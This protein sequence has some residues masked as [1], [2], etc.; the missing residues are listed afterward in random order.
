MDF[1]A[2]EKAW[3]SKASDLFKQGTSLGT[4]ETTTANKDLIKSYKNALYKKNRLWWNKTSLENY[5]D[6]QIIPRGLRVQIYPSFELGDDTL[7][8]RWISAAMTCSLDFM[9][10]IVDK[11]SQ[12]LKILDEEI[13]E[14]EKNIL[15]QLPVDNFDTSLAEINKE[16]DKWE[17]QISQNKLKKLQRDLK[18]YENDKIYRWQ[19]K[20][21]KKVNKE[22][23]EE[24][25]P[26]LSHERT[27]SESSC[28]STSDN[29][30]T[31]ASEGENYTIRERRPRRGN[32]RNEKRLHDIFTRTK[33]KKSFGEQAKV[34]NLSQ[35]RITETQLRLLEKGLT[36]SP[37]CR[38][39]PFTAVKDL[40][41][42]AR[43]LIFKKFHYKK[44]TGDMIATGEENETLQILESLLDENTTPTTKYSLCESV[45]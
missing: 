14:M 33:G 21:A 39:D 8:K 5:L 27:A 4:Q 24:N 40:H 3:Q 28:A 19:Y 25:R 6:K 42:F 41:L 9:Q 2:R 15:K 30:N 20:N 1:K 36:F 13:D 16:V 45:N 31:S 12:S 44:K 35:H 37:S 17:S 18:D 11:N 38:L 23:M 43:K 29:H 7:I 22:N 32:P 26:D 10:I 34:V